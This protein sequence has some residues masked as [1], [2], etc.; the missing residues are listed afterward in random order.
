MDWL[1]QY[2]L[3]ELPPLAAG[4]R[5]AVQ[6]AGMLVPL[7]L[8]VD[9]LVLI[10]HQ[11]DVFQHLLQSLHWFCETNSLTV[12]F[13][14]SAWVAGGMVPR[15][16][17]WE[18]LYYEGAVLS[19]TPKYKYLGLE[20]DGSPSMGAMISARLTAAQTTWA[21]LIGLIS[22]LG[23]QDRATRLLLFDMYVHSSLLYGGPVWGIELSL[24]GWWG[25]P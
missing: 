18:H 2:I 23:W 13:S 7:L 19:C 9:D 4:T 16:A 15:E 12:N 5:E 11:H 8:F 22:G 3:Q 17:D 14:K 6:V 25:L 21:K 24:A 10:S 20:W 1:E